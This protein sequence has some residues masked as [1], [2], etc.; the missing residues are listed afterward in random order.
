MALFIIFLQWTIKSIPC[1]N[2]TDIYFIWFFIIIRFNTK[3]IKIKKRRKKEKRKKIST[4]AR[5]NE[6]KEKTLRLEILLSDGILLVILYFQIQ[7]RCNIIKTITFKITYYW[8]K[9]ATHSFCNMINAFLFSHCFPWAIYR[10]LHH[11]LIC[12]TISISN[13]RVIEDIMQLDW[14]SVHFQNSFFL[15]CLEIE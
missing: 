7:I 5:K 6:R 10:F 2:T 14:S 1:E 15:H 4:K 12:G 9:P 3:Y 8:A 11:T 13:K